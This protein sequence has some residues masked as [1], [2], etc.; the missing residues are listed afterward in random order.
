MIGINLREAR[1]A[2]RIWKPRN[3]NVLRLCEV[4]EISTDLLHGKLQRLHCIHAAGVTHLLLSCLLNR[5][6][7]IVRFE[8]SY[9]V[10]TGPLIMS[11]RSC[12]ASQA[13]CFRVSSRKLRQSR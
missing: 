7:A 6:W 13:R 10:A 11:R 4:G 9:A 5:V 2:W 8:I 1:I 3:W 12:V